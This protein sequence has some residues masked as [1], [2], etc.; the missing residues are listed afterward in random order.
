M[1]R[2]V[3]IVISSSAAL[4]TSVAILITNGYI[5][6]LKIRYTKLRDW[7]IVITLYYG[8]VLKNSLV[9]ERFD[10]REAGELKKFIIIILIK[11]LKL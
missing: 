2:T 4:S 3:V 6:I 7:I 11:D 9:D 10:E 1:N 8:K 5:S